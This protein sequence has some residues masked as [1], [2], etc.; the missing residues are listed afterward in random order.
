MRR[1]QKACRCHKCQKVQRL[2]DQ[3]RKGCSEES[4]DDNADSTDR[5][6][7]VRQY[8]PKL[9]RPRSRFEGVRTPTT[10]LNGRLRTKTALEQ[11]SRTGTY[12]GDKEIPRHHLRGANAKTGYKFP[13]YTRC[14]GKMTQEKKRRSYNG[15]AS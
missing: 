3:T 6:V 10:E 5:G 11:T 1:G 8:D 15:L 13:S 14:R 9:I 7:P 2:S 12:K 4:R